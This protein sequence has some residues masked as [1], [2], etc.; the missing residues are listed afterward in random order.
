MSMRIGIGYDIHRLIPGSDLVLGG[1]SIPGDVQADA[2]S[3]GDVVL[4][5]LCDALLGAVAA[6]DIGEHF[7]DTDAQWAGIDSSELLL[8]VLTLPELQAWQLVNCD[9]N[10]IAQKPRLASRKALMRAR[11]GDLLGITL[12]RVS[13]KARTN[14]HCDAIGNGEAIACQCVVLLEE[15]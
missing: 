6:G 5:A 2:H 3:D 11:L 8:R 13:V 9:L 7:P 10:I 14:E 12:D 4:H 1:I 15:R